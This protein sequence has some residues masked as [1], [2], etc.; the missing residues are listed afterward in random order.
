M[1]VGDR[2]IAE[3][4]EAGRGTGVELPCAY[5]V[6]DIELNREMTAGLLNS[7]GIEAASYPSAQGFLGAFDPQRPGCLLLDI[8]M[9]GMSGLELQAELNRRGVVLPVVMITAHADVPVAIQAMREGAYEFIEKPVDNRH[10]LDVVRRAFEVSV[11]RLRD[12]SERDSIRQRYETLS[13]RELQVLEAMVDG[14][15]NK[16]IAYD[17]GISQ[18]TVEVH[19]SNVMEKMR[20]QSLAELVRMTIRLGETEARVE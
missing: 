10:L 3:R 5:V 2:V 18:R 13:A 1:C 7:A 8:R 14:R 17:L 11:T 20:A 4:V 16:Q 12:Q 15:L 6:D 9:P 19:R